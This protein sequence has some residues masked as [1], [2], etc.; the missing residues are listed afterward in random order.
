MA[1]APL[2]ALVRERQSARPHDVAHHT[3]ICPGKE[4]AK[5][6]DVSAASHPDLHLLFNEVCHGAWDCW[7]RRESRWA[8]FGSC[9]SRVR[10][11]LS[12]K[13]APTPVL[14]VK[15]KR[16]RPRADDGKIRRYL[17][18]E[19]NDMFCRTTRQGGSSFSLEDLP[20]KPHTD[21]TDLEEKQDPKIQG[22]QV[23]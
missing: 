21:D 9:I 8:A 23:M 18:E 16:T 15:E 3:R 14:R 17:C 2:L 4:S 22:F 19:T 5:T 7:A 13:H 10:V 12:L 11:G 1:A 6:H 20:S